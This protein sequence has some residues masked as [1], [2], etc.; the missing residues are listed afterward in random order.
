MS[1]YHPPIAYTYHVKFNGRPKGSN[2]KIG[3][4]PEE[5]EITAEDDDKA[6]AAALLILRQWVFELDGL[7]LRAPQYRAYAWV[8]LIKTTPWGYE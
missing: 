6:R 4:I 2:P 1:K 5:F 7:E 8:P 3:L